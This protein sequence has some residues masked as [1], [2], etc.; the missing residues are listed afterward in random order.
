MKT[1]YQERKAELR[2]E[3]IEWQQTLSAWHPSD[4]ELAYCQEYF[5]ELGRR[6][7]LLREFRENGIC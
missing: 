3:A 7:G 6:Y 4:S 1:Y 2:E 5:E